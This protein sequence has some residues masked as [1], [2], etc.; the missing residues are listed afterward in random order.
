MPG[1]PSYITS[2]TKYDQSRKSIPAKAVPNT[3][4]TPAKVVPIHSETD[5]ELVWSRTYPFRETMRFTNKGVNKDPDLI[6]IYSQ[7]PAWPGLS[8]CQPRQTIFI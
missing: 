4:F 1:L 6:I 5:F 8:T 3:P 2:Q 7:P